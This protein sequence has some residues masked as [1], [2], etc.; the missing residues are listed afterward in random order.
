M[1]SLV[2]EKI[3]QEKRRRN[4]IYK[5]LDYSLSHLSYFD[6][7]SKDALKIVIQTKGLASFFQKK[8]ITSEMLLIGFFSQKNDFRELFLEYD[9]DP[10]LIFYL[11]CNKNS[12]Y[13]HYL[14]IKEY[15][16][17]MNKEE[18]HSQKNFSFSREVTSIFEQATNNALSRFKTPIISS[19]ILFITIMEDESIKASS[20]IKTMVKDPIKWY[21]LRYELMKKIHLQEST[22]RGQI[23]INQHYFACLL[24]RELTDVEL[25]RVIQNQNFPYAVNLFRNT[26]VST[27]LMQ[28]IFETLLVDIKQSMRLTKFRKYSKKS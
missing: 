13:E 28:N 6:F 1:N 3:T 10:N 20:I 5:S 9:I 15:F 27:I 18:N 21:L 22:I 19:E 17:G 16:S 23:I 24:K 4:Q 11:T 26:L 14:M 8:T 2:T 7:F 25:D 12:I